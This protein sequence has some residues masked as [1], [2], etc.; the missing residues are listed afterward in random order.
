MRDFPGS[1]VVRT[2]CFHHRGLGLSSIPGW[3]A[4]IWRPIKKKEK[5]SSKKIH[6]EQSI[7][8]LHK[9]RLSTV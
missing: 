7:K 9:Y 8:F 3:E 5:S 4:K 2:P 1:P 6:D